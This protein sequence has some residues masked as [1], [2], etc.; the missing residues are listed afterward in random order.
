[1]APADMSDGQFGRF[2]ELEK[3]RI[4]AQQSEMGGPTSNSSPDTTLHPA[5]SEAQPPFAAARKEQDDLIARRN[6]IAAENTAALNDHHHQ[7]TDA[8]H[9]LI[10]ANP[11]MRN[12]PADIKK[13]IVALRDERNIIEDRMDRRSDHHIAASTAPARKVPEISSMGPVD[14]SGGYG[15][16]GSPVPEMNPVPP[17]PKKGGKGEL[18]QAKLNLG[19]PPTELT[20]A[21]LVKSRQK[22]MTEAVINSMRV[23]PKAGV[24]SSYKVKMEDPT[25]HE[26]ITAIFKP[27]DS[28]ARREVAAFDA[29][30]ILGLE[31]LVPTTVEREVGHRSDIPPGWHHGSMQ[32]WVNDSTVAGEMN[33]DDSFGG[34]ESDVAR[35]A[36]FDWVIGN[37]DRHEWNW[38]VRNKDHKIQLIDHG[39]VFYPSRDFRSAFWQR[40][41]SL[42]LPIP[43]EIKDWEAKWPEIEAYLKSKGFNAGAISKTKTRLDELMDA[44]TFDEVKE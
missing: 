29:A 20:P 31:D 14:D 4:A 30:A 33:Y 22:R 26:K 23:N 37:T 15:G 24:S 38:V 41:K 21:Q 36:A 28:V 9:A 3:R 43:Q 17:K 44:D 1:M 2:N 35:A 18:K 32:E 34:S 10:A 12:R 40:A 8:L 42:D 6:L 19:L 11:I 7:V 27:E 39:F 5:F 16:K 13:R 25:T